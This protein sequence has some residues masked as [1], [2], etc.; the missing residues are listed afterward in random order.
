MLF[1]SGLFLG[2]FAAFLLLYYL[3]RNHLTARNLLIL[4]AS[5]IFYGAWDYRFLGLLIFT[6]VMDYYVARGLDQS[7]NP[8]TRKLLLTV[9]IVVNLT[10]LG[11]FKYY[12]FFVESAATLLRS[13]NI[14][15]NLWTLNIILP[16]GISFYTFQE[17]SYTIDVYRKE[18]PASRNLVHFL[19]FVAFFP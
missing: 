1:N 16:V 12:V 11:F 19:S 7:L 8:R 9:S 6:S 5:Y 14:Q 17:M 10:I 2:F 15:A 18:L 3:V 4:I 13:F